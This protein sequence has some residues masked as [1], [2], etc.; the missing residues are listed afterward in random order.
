MKRIVSINVGNY[1]VHSLD[2]EK[3]TITYDSRLS[4][5]L[6]FICK[7][8]GVTIE[9]FAT[10]SLANLLEEELDWI[11]HNNHDNNLPVDVEEIENHSETV[12]TVKFEANSWVLKNE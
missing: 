2:I 8:L 11:R 6:D 3:R 9:D 10:L 12:K 7:I 5:P 1:V 4:L